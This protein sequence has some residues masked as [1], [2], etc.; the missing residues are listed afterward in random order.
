MSAAAGPRT[1][2]CMCMYIYVCM[3]C[4]YESAHASVRNAPLLHV[5]GTYPVNKSEHT[6]TYLPAYVGTRTRACVR[7]RPTPW[8]M[9]CT[10]TATPA[11]VALRP[12]L[13]HPYI[14]TYLFIRNYTGLSPSRAKQ[15]GGRPLPLSDNK[16]DV[17]CRTS[18]GPGAGR[19]EDVCTYTN[20]RSSDGREPSW[21]FPLFLVT[22]LFLPRNCRLGG[23]SEVR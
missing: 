2:S 8:C 14:L 21:P 16:L 11:G 6:D 7:A 4:M 9:Y 20:Y 19:R 12:R 5:W 17:R 15:I 13:C 23:G 18:F 10:Y 3:Y 1:P 22:S